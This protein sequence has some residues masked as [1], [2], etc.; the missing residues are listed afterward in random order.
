MPKQAKE[1]DEGGARP[2]AKRTREGSSQTDDEDDSTILE[3][4]P[5]TWWPFSIVVGL[6]ITLKPRL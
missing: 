4:L 6:I 1:R 3:L 2:A 5:M